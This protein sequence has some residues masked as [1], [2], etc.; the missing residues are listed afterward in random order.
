MVNEFESVATICRALRDAGVRYLIVGGLA[1]LFHG[2][3]RPTGDM[4]LVLDMDEANLKKALA[5]LKQLGY[6]PRAPVPIEAFALRSNRESWAI[7]KHMKVFSLFDPAQ[8]MIEVD[9]FLSPPL[10]LE[11]AFAAAVTF[12]L[13]PG[14][15]LPV[16]GL[17]HL[18]DLKRQA[19][20]P[21]DLLDIRQLE[22]LRR[23]RHDRS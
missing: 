15:P 8:R 23:E 3:G 12:E 20:R 6:C 17:D 14:L 21:Q 18:L 13:E 11:R 5:A 1:V 22:A 10:D 9:L 16:V 7:D 2:Y 4:D 19:G